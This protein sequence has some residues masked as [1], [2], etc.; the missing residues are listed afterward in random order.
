MYLTGLT[1]SLPEPFCLLPQIFTQGLFGV[2]SNAAPPRRCS[3]C[4]HRLTLFSPAFGTIEQDAV[5]SSKPSSAVASPPWHYRNMRIRLTGRSCLQMV[6]SILWANTEP[7][8]GVLG[9][10]RPPP[11]YE[12]DL[13]DCP[14]IR[15]AR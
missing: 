5:G 1:W 2:M 4:T 6:R 14:S 11:G 12:A 7:L 13:A 3:R 15:S 8:L 9:W 10:P